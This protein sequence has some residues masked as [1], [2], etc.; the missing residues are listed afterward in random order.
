MHKLIKFEVN[1]HKS[2]RYLINLL[3]FSDLKVYKVECQGSNCL[4]FY[5]TIQLDYL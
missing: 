3:I 2:N 5:F 4:V 1:V